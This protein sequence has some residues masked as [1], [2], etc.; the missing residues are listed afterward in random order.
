MFPSGGGGG[1]LA[2]DLLMSSCAYLSRG[3][4]GWTGEEVESLTRRCEFSLGQ[5][6]A[7]VV[8]LSGTPV[9]QTAEQRVPP[10]AGALLVVRQVRKAQ[11]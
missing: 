3:E 10:V 1:Y 5:G 7:P 2:T 9:K 11:V 6:D 4:E 8:M